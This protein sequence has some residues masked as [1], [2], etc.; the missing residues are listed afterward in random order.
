MDQ[1]VAEEA[2]PAVAV[3]RRGLVL[4]ASLMAIFMP[5]VESSIVATALPTIIGHLGGFHLFSWVFAVPLL[6]MAVTIPLYGRL[7]DIYGRRQVFFTGTAIF[8]IGTALCGFARSMELLIV[9]RAIQGIGAGA[10][11]P[12]AMTIIGDIYTPTERARIQGAMSAVWG[13]AA[14]VGPATSA[15][16]VETVHWSIVFWV[17][18]PI[19]VVSLAMFAVFLSEQVERRPHRIDFLGGALLI[20]GVG[21]LM[22]ALVQALN[23]GGTTIA[24]LVVVGV[25][26]LAWL[27][28]HESRVPEP[29]L[30]LGLWRQRVLALC[31][32]G[33]FTAS[34][35]YMAVS[36]LLPIYVQ[37]AMGYSAAVS[38]FV[39]GAASV[40][41]MVAS[42]VAGR[43]MVHTSYRL[44]FAIGGA[45]LI[46]GSAVLLTLDAGSGVAWPV[47]GSLLIGNG[48]GFCNTTFI[49]AIQGTVAW[50]E[51]GVATGSQMFMRMIG[52]SVGA[53]LFGAIVNFGVNR[54][55][56]GVGDSVNRLLLPE[57]RG[58]LDPEQIARLADAIAVAA[59][60][61]FLIATLIGVATLVLV[62][63]FPR[64]LSP[65]RTAEARSG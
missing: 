28:V 32:I 17:N 20:V 10:I 42:I 48:M 25:G 55:L 37:G 56:P 35:T 49:V 9:F 45:S 23:F 33:G 11:Q 57:T 3:P 15:F 12:I 58:A 63:A 36:A 19:G 51:R 4:A 41:W 14:V 53:A 60:G 18:L 26:A 29:M 8:L 16:L 65:T 24:A 40:S 62:F 38:G 52:M 13:F 21:A 61:A 7:A 50:R 44:T 64:G 54:Q 27:L 22:L 31:N 34:A 47:A 59:Q 46:A 1:T 30:P 5:A 6:T 39:V 2:R 43:L